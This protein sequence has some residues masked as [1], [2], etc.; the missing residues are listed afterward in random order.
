VGTTVEAIKAGLRS[1]KAGRGTLGQV[2][3]IVD[4]DLAAGK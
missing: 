2:A 1:L 4:L 3:V